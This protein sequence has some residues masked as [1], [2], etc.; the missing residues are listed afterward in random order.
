MDIEIGDTLWGV[1]LLLTTIIIV[2]CNLDIEREEYYKKIGYELL[3][4]H[5]YAE[6]VAH[7]PDEAIINLNETRSVIDENNSHSVEIVISIK[8][9]AKEEHS[10]NTVKVLIDKH[11]NELAGIVFGYGPVE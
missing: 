6:S 7:G 1:S 11:S 10:F 5:E 4:K 9:L 2:S 3:K 8:F